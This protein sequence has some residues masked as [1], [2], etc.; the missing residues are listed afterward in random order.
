MSNFHPCNIKLLVFDLDSL[1]VDFD[2]ESWKNF[3]K[4]IQV[5]DD[6]DFETVLIGKHIDLTNWESY[7]R[8]SV[9]QGTCEEAF[10]KNS[11]LYGTDVFWFSERSSLQK[12]LSN[13]TRNFAGSNAQTEQN[14]GLHFQNLY[15]M[16]QIFHPSKITAK[17]I[18]SDL[19]KLKLV[20][21]QVPLVLGI[22]GPDDCGHSFFVGELTDNLES[23]EMLV[24]SLD[25]SQ[26]LGTEF[27]KF[28]NMKVV[29]NSS[30]WRS[31]E[32][33]NW[34]VEDVLSPYCNGKQVYF[35]NPPAILKDF[36]ISI[37]PFFL[38][39]EMILIIWGTTI[40]L[41]EL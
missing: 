30:F 37:F 24:S 29:R 38:S 20:S 3:R 9:L 39:P 11:S 17:E 8:L 31:Q 4:F 13:F 27:R 5:L 12:K 28:D 33:Q 2:Q 36:E 21:E 41:P 15:D 23:Q 6:R 25:L 26:V 16:L 10:Q 1:T 35:E 19:L 40:F 32:I 7:S 18:S 14:G 22:G 34:V